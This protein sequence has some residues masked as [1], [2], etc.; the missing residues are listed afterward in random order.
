MHGATWDMLGIWVTDWVCQK[1]SQTCGR[2]RCVSGW[3]LSCGVSLRCV[4]GGHMDVDVDVD[5]DARAVRCVCRVRVC[6]VH[7]GGAGNMVVG[8]ECACWG[9][10][11]R[12]RGRVVQTC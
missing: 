1:S 6:W 5:M 2:A 10:S 7:I 12:T 9:R 11:E 4:V 8:P 3:G